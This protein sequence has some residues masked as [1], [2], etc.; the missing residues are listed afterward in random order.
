MVVAVVVV[1]CDNTRSNA[2]NHVVGAVRRAAVVVPEVVVAVGAVARAVA[3]PE[4]RRLV[5]R[6]RRIA[7]V[8]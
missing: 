6:Y 8:M 5:A 1:L 2:E 7:R 3:V 4:A